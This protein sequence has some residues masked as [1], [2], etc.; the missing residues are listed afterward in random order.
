MS[1]FYSSAKSCGVPVLLSYSIKC[2]WYNA[3]A[4]HKAC[5]YACSVNTIGY[6]VCT[7]RF[8]SDLQIKQT[9]HVYY[10][11]TQ[12][13]K[14]L[15]DTMSIA[16]CYAREIYFN[17]RAFSTGFSRMGQNLN[18]I[19][20]GKDTIKTSGAHVF[21]WSRGRAQMN[22]TQAQTCFLRGFLLLIMC[23]NIHQA[24]YI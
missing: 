16:D 19:Q 1:A 24:K 18:N 13:E 20:E 2:S 6:N 10:K 12:V 17:L 14:Q 3:C 5:L 9:F 4:V 21:H 23:I 22:S 7:C 11:R 8:Q 15:T